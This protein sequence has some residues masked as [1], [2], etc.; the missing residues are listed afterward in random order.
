M[1]RRAAAP[2]PAAPACA[3]CTRLT[4]EQETAQDERDHSRAS[5]CRVLLARHH[6]ETHG[7]EQ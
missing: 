3:E 2:A 5:D 4:S 7:G 6:A 1:D